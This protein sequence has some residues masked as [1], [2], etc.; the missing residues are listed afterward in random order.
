MVA[1][2]TLSGRVG[3]GLAWAA[4]VLGF[5]GVAFVRSYQPRARR[6]G[7]LLLLLTSAFFALRYTLTFLAP[8]SFWPTA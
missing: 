2:D 8:G 4:P 1:R 3:L 6:F 5:G 7:V